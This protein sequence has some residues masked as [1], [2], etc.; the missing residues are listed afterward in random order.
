MRRSTVKSSVSPSV[1]G[2]AATVGV[3]KLGV[4]ELRLDRASASVAAAIGE[5]GRCA[6]AAEAELA[7]GYLVSP[8]SEIS[9]G[10]TTR[11]A[12][13]KGVM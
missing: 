5:M 6:V 12:S 9:C 8:I 13:K 11:S 10:R 4:A 2:I 1:A 3:A 7:E